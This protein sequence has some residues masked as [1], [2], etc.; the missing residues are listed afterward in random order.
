[1]HIS[2]HCDIEVKQWTGRKLL[3]LKILV[4]SHSHYFFCEI[5]YAFMQ[6]KFLELTDSF[7]LV[8]FRFECKFIFIRL[9]LNLFSWF[10]S[11]IA[12]ASTP[13]FIKFSKDLIFWPW[14]TFIMWNSWKSIAN[15]LFL[16][17]HYR[18]LLHQS[19]LINWSARNRMTLHGLVL[20]PDLFLHWLLSLLL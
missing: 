2:L 14:M 4:L 16:C 1:M 13:L 3:L 10:V 7:C 11:F 19:C 9:K 20:L 15:H 17:F 18:F 8:Y 5:W 6:I 12:F